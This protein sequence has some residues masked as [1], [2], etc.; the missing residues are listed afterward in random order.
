MFFVSS[1]NITLILLWIYF[2]VLGKAEAI[3]PTTVQK[4]Y[5]VFYAW[6]LRDKTMTDKLMY[7]PNDGAQNCPF[8]ILKLVVEIFELS[9]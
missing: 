4:I 6:I 7:I 2:Y 3:P 8:C 1:G 9:T 5:T